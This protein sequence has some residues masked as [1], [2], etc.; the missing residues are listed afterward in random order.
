MLGDGWGGTRHHCHMACLL[1]CL[2]YTLVEESQS[3]LGVQVKVFMPLYSGRRHATECR[4]RESSRVAGP[5]LSLLH[6]HNLS[7]ISKLLGSTCP[8]GCSGKGRHGT[9]G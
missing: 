2:A 9:H 4:S 3:L 6:I 1:P 8:R 7:P 5:V